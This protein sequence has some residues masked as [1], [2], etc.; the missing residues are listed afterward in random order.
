MYCLPVKGPILPFRGIAPRPALILLLLLCGPAPVLG[1]EPLTLHGVVSDAESGRPLGTAAVRVVGSLGGTFTNMDGQYSIPVMPGPQTVIVTTRGYLPQTFE[2]EVDAGGQELDVAL[3]PLR[4]RERPEGFALFPALPGDTLPTDA[5]NFATPDSARIRHNQVGFSGLPRSAAGEFMLYLFDDIQ[6]MA[7]ADRI[8]DVDEGHFQWIGSVTDFNGIG[9]GTGVFVLRD[10]HMTGDIRLN[11]RFFK[12]L[13]V[14]GPLH[15]VIEVDLRKLPGGLPP[16]VP[17]VQEAEEAEGQEFWDLLDLPRFRDVPPWIRPFELRWFESFVRPIPCGDTWNMT[18]G[19][20]P[21]VRVLALYTDEVGWTTGDFPAELE[22]LALET[23]IALDSSRVRL[24]VTPAH[25]Q[26]ISVVDTAYADPRVLLENLH[27]PP[28][29]TDY[30]LVPDLRDMYH[31]DVV[32]LF[33]TGIIGGGEA[34]TM[35][36]VTLDFEDSAFAVV[37]H[38]SA[39]FS[40]FAHELGH[41]MGAQHPRDPG[42]AAPIYMLPYHYNHGYNAPDSSWNT[43]M[44]FA[45]SGRLSLYSNPELFKEGVALGLP[46]TDP[47]AADVHRAL[48]NTAGVVSAFRLTPVWFVS[49]GGS[50]PWLERRV[51]EETVS[52]LRFGDF[53][54]DLEADAFKVDLEMNSWW[55]SRSASEPWKLLNQF[56]TSDPLVPIS[57][58]AFGNFDDDKTTDVFRVDEVENT[59]W[60]SK[61]GSGNWKVL[62][63]FGPSDPVI[64]LRDLA[65]ADFDGDSVTDVLRSDQVS[66]QWWVSFAGTGDWTEL[67]E[68]EEL[69]KL[70]VSDLAF[71]YF[72]EDKNADVFR[73]DGQR[74]WYSSGGVGAWKVLREN[75][76]DGV[77][78]L[79]FGDF[80]GDSVTDVL[81]TTGLYWFLSKKGSTSWTIV[82]RDCHRLSALAFG[83]FDGDGTI[84]MI[85]A[86]IRP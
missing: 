34:N 12:V 86:G 47:K 30:E 78:D 5:F 27:S 62:K 22:L 83:D 42:E 46:S 37:K 21:E 3:V 74:W 55:W 15:V 24:H 2:F 35:E 64:P 52:E 31:A 57:K 20:I 28:P 4:E 48:S 17:P 54:G 1:Q 29:G 69:R 81:K 11:G 36:N 38:T 75:A 60:W 53:D 14:E 63:E 8:I 19:P 58:L 73:A 49:S 76:R 13:P 72:D 84:D 77:Q 65:F 80:D 32:V 45:G 44:G 16:V 56:G 40:I 61:S 26:Q 79:A 25:V 51:A 39:A 41:V 43:L 85:R 9:R 33:V 23:N 67:G 82:R 68:D 70:P 7:Q 66:G 6:L 10:E 71:G 18:S 50:S 59:W